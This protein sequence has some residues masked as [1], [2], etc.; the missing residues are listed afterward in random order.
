MHD[1]RDYI[2]EIQQNLK[3][4]QAQPGVTATENAL[5]GMIDGLAGLQRLTMERVAAMELTL[6]G[7]TTEAARRLQGVIEATRPE[8]PEA[9]VPVRDETPEAPRVH[10]R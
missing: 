10:G 8:R 7:R 1:P 4:L 6:Q 3:K 2:D 9:P 5:F